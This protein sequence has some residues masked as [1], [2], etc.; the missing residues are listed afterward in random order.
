MIAGDTIAALATGAGPSAIAVVRISG[1][2]AFELGQKLCLRWRE[3]LQPRVARY[4]PFVRAGQPFD[5]G[6]YLAFPG[7]ASYTGEDLL[8][9]HGH[10]G[11]AARVLLQAAVE[12]GARLAAPGE[13][14]ER[15]FLNGKLDLVQAESVA[16]LIAAQTERALRAAASG[17]GGALS[18][19]VDEFENALISLRGRVE[20][21]IDFPA[22]AEGAEVG[23]QESVAALGAKVR[24]LAGSYARGRRLFGRSEVVLVGPVNAGKSSLLNA[25]AGEERALVDAEPGTTR[26]LVTADVELRGMPL[27][28]VD[29]AGWREARGVEAR[30]I[31]RGRDAAARAELV[32]WVTSVEALEP[33]PEPDWIAV[34]AKRD[35]QPGSPLP[36]GV[37]AVSARTGEG[38]DALRA[39]VA[40]RL[41]AGGEDERLVV[42]ERQALELTRAAEALE[43]ASVSVGVE[44]VAE[45]LALAS[46]ALEQ[47]RGRGSDADVVEAV[48]RQFCIGK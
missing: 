21:L 10:G 4:S 15:A 34:A 22:E 48:F 2:R 35:L 29:T 1:P 20:G 19:Q 9:L 36:E 18:E 23:L 5:A 38:L 45:E 46:R 11:A 17:L 39:A 40:V 41:D 37:I 44:L 16:A 30:G 32:V 43:R 42:T 33:P 12:Q 47:V 26:D 7:P 3:P 28:L 31:A 6:L 24:A 8:E 25:L 13:L 27:R 14:S